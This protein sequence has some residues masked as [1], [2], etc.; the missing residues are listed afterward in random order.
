MVRPKEIDVSSELSDV[1][2]EDDF[3]S[4]DSE[5]S[6]LPSD[7]ENSSKETNKLSAQ[8]SLDLSSKI[9]CGKCRKIISSSALKFTEPEQKLQICENCFVSLKE[10]D[11]N[12]ESSSA[13]SKKPDLK[14]ASVPVILIDEKKTIK[15]D[16]S[17]S[18]NKKSEDVYLLKDSKESQTSTSKR[19]RNV[20]YFKEDDASDFIDDSS[21]FVP[22]GNEDQ[23]GSELEFD[24]DPS[25]D[26]SDFGVKKGSKKGTSKKATGSKNSKNSALSDSGKKPNS[27]L[28]KTKTT[29]R[30]V[31]SKTLK[32]PLKKPPSTNT[33]S[34][35]PANKSGGVGLLKSNSR[36]GGLKLASPKSASKSSTTPIQTGL[37]SISKQSSGL[38]FSSAQNSANSASGSPK[39]SGLSKVPSMDI[40]TPT[41][42]TGKPSF[43]KTNPLS[44]QLSGS[45]SGFTNA[46]S[47]PKSTINPSISGGG[48]ISSAASGYL[49]PSSG[50][51]RVG[52]SR[53]TGVSS[54]KHLL[55]SIGSVKK[56]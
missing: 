56:N 7:E 49:A 47:I 25:S 27:S 37:S 51:R 32:S 15:S 43:V 45:G 22:S 48:V 21:D 3:L 11:T 52:L 46:S 28:S 30:K 1:P 19:K 40:K 23:L 38:G 13:S 42:N 26:D 8:S 2:T 31:Q 50:I 14:G 41:S 36:L 5:I 44:K 55:S 17:R 10:T 4:S 20:K 12:D 18:R 54:N 33:V 29:P 53:R 35:N 9:F 24:A 39:V 6:I 16:G 34:S